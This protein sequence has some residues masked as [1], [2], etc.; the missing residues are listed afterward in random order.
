MKTF[1]AEQRR[2]WLCGILWALLTLNPINL[3]PFR[4]GWLLLSAGLAV[5]VLWHWRN[6]RRLWYGLGL[7]VL[8][9]LGW[10]TVGARRTTV[11]EIRA[12]Y[13]RALM[14]YE[15]VGYLWGGE[16]RLGIDCSGLVRRGFIDAQLWLGLTHGD[17]YALGLAAF[18]W[19]HD[20]SAA[21]MRDGEAGTT[22][23]IKDNIALNALDYSWLN[24][25]DIMVTS[26][27]EH[28]MVYLGNREWISA[29]PTAGEVFRAS[30]PD[31]RV[32]W[33][34]TDA[35]IFRWRWLAN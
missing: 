4:I 7:S 2:L 19:C 13:I 11:E 29:D 32:H 10:F 17:A 20:Q 9:V 18:L 8:L 25:G 35:H 15:G 26:N 21:A 3:L 27:G 24:P 28:C 1:T 34:I 30:A 33:F 12:E 5:Y 22:I 23:S 16:G 6:S 14:G 31:S